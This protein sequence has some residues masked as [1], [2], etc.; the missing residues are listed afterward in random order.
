MEAAIYLLAFA[1]TMLVTVIVQ[2]VEAEETT[3]KETY[4]KFGLPE[5]AKHFPPH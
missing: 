4:V 1:E 2:P 3:D 5:S